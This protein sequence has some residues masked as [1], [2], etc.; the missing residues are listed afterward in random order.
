[1]WTVLILFNRVQH[2][3]IVVADYLAR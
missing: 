1:M 3:T 2:I